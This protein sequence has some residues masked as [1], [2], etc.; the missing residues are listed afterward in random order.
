MLY[1][2]TPADNVAETVRSIGA[3]HARSSPARIAD[4]EAITRYSAE[5]L[6]LG[7]PESL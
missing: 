3:P 6:T 5:A 2:A 4:G 1:A 7:N